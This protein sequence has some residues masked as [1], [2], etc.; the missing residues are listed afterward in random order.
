[1]ELE[2]PAVTARPSGS[3]AD[4]AAVPIVSVVVATHNRPQRLA[5]LL[6]ALRAQDVADG[7][8]ELLVV[9]D[10]SPPG[11]DEVLED[12]LVRGDIN[13]RILRI[14]RPGG[15]AAARNAGWLLA[16]AP[17]VAFTDDD[18]VPAPG[19]LAA[20]LDAQTKS[21]G[22]IIQGPTQP[23]PEECDRISLFS[24]TVVQ[25]HL[26]PNYETCNIFYPRQVLESLSGFDEGF[27]RSDGRPMLGPAGEDTDLAW[28]AL[29]AGYTAVFAPGAQVFHAVERIGPMRKLRLALRWTPCVRILAE[30]PQTR[31]MLQ[32]RVFWNTWH[33]L[34]WRAALSS[35]GPRWLRRL[36]WMRYALQLQA[37]GRDVGAGAWSIP[38]FVVHDLIETWAIV[39]GAVKYRTFV[40]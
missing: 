30:H 26:G 23:D 1:M 14:E 17:L 22:A 4:G 33:Y 10:G 9:D 37:R 12:E 6:G 39:R 2:A 34:L 27:G 25:A 24:H 18:C 3:A 19:W 11:T 32:R 5:R 20:A 31:A 40:L 38:F 8:F 35:F 21:P 36:V 13:L 28:R 16:R 29:E 7:T 15:P